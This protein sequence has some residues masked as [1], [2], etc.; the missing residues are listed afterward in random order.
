MRLIFVYFLLNWIKYEKIKKGG[1][2]MKVKDCMCSNVTWVTKDTNVTE[3]AKLMGQHHIGCVPVCDES[4][5]ILGIVT[6]RDIILRSVA[7]NKDV[8]ST[9]VEDIMTGSVC[10]CGQDASVEEAQ[11]LMSELQIRRLP[12]VENGKVVGILTLGDLTSNKKVDTQEVTD[13]LECICNH[14]NK[15]AE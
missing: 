13:T 6:D 10:T 2:V 12:V 14:T 3:V 9:K 11:N 5:K 7:C 8:N 15:N 1:K 4:N